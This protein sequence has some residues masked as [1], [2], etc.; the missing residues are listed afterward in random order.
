M[1]ALE[2]LVLQE[3]KARPC[4]VPW[5]PEMDLCSTHRH[6]RRISCPRHF[7]AILALVKV[8]PML[9]TNVAPASTELAVVFSLL[10]AHPSSVGDG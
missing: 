6:W 3:R 5:V 8:K 4:Q 9:P 7:L 1:N 2:A 10:Q